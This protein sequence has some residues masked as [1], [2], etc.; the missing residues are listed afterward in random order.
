MPELRIPSDVEELLVQLRSPLASDRLDAARLLDDVAATPEIDRA[1]LE[2][3]RDQDA[4]VRR[5]AMHSLSCAHCKPDGCLG[6]AAVD[7]LIDA[8]LHD[9]S[10]R[11]RRWAAGVTMYAQVGAPSRLIDAYRHV[12]AT[13]TDRVLRERAATF[14]AALELPRGDRPYAEWLAEWEPHRQRLLAS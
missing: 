3:A 14:L 12:L 2:A 6:P 7:V 11:N 4:K 9:V 1:L 8:L 10:I 5:A 13:T